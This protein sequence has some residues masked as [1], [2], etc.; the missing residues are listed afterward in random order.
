MSRVPRKSL[1]LALSAAL[2]LWPAAPKAHPHIFID[3]GLRLIVEEGRVTAVE[4]TWLYDELYTLILLEDYGLDE[5]F[6]LTLTEDEVAATLGFDLNWNSG[7]EG[8]LTLLRGDTALDLGA[9]EPVSLDLV[10]PGQL[11]TTHRRAVSDL[12]D[13]ALTA[14][15]YDREF[16]IA[17]EMT[18]AME[19]AGADCTDE[20]I[21]ADLDAAYDALEAAM[22]EIGGVIAAEDNFPPVGALFA[23]RVVF[24]CAG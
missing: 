24:E 13:G 22:E 2:A 14:Q 17:F 10:A 20:L 19:V 21:R 18:G 3:A 4:V 23:D 16:Y 8:G 12:G 11:R 7:F 6:D 15:V 5:D 9:P 1:F